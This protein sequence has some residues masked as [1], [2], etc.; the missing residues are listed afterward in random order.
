MTEQVK[1]L[2]LNSLGNCRYTF[3]NG[4]DAV[5]L[6]GEYATDNYNEIRE[7]RM[8]VENGHPHIYVDKTRETVDANKLDPMEALKERIIAEHE[9]KKLHMRMGGSTV[10]DSHS[11]QSQVV[12]ANTKTVGEAMSGSSSVDGAV[13][14]TTSLENANTAGAQ[15]VH[16][17]TGTAKIVPGV[18]K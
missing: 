15:P 5:F 18:K 12:T 2:F 4:K 7:L 13:V 11:I 3:S 1:H 9:A 14:Q 6:N 8:E 10:E 16:S 17:Q